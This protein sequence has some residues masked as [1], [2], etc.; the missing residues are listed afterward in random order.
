M[1]TYNESILNDM[2]SYVKSY[3]CERGQ[4]PSYREIMKQL[5]L[6]SLSMVSR[7]LNILYD[8]NLLKKD[9]EGGVSISKNIEKSPTILAPVVGTVTCGSPIYAY[10]NIEG[11]YQLPVDIFGN[12]KSFILHAEGDSMQNVGIQSGD[13]LVVKKCE[14]AENGDIVVALL[15]DSATVK[16]FFKKSDK[17]ILHPENE[18]YEDII[19]KDIKILGIVQHCI[20]KF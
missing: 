7:Y 10:E 6:S 19:A 15:E 12:N 16:R 3:Q 14:T 2:L 8:K 4:S 5:N 1:K 17:I 9:K 11:M 18:K 13:L 20:H